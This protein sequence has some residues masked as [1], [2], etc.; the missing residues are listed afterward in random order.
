MCAGL[1]LKPARRLRRSQQGWC[2]YAG[3]GPAGGCAGSGLSPAVAPPAATA[4]LS[5]AHRVLPQP[6][7]VQPASTGAA[8]HGRRR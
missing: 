2:G 1:C 3:K 4:M 7:L 8:M 6:R 5:P